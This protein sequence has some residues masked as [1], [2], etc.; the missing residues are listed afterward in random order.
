VIAPALIA[1]IL[2]LALDTF[3]VSAAVGVTGPSRRQRLRLSGLFALFEGGTPAI[4]VRLGATWQ[5][6]PK[7][8]PPTAAPPGA[9]P[10]TA[11][12]TKLG[13]RL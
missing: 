4:G 11:G 7:S 10:T 8:L 9:T 6:G 5:S 1:L 13:G 3:A 2:P 12:A